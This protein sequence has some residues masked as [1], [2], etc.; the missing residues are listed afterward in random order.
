ME[1]AQPR[2][3]AF[4]SRMLVKRDRHRWAQVHPCHRTVYR[5]VIVPAIRGG[6]KVDIVLGK[7][8]RCLAGADPVRRQV[9]PLSL[10]LALAFRGSPSEAAAGAVRYYET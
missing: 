5:P 9:G 2:P 3:E 6:A 7:R 8:E 10:G 4:A 1:R